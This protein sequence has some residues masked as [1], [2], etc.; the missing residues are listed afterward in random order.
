MVKQKS[1]ELLNVPVMKDRFT[2]ETYVTFDDLMMTEIKR[3]L[4]LLLKRLP[5]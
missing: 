5:T 1:D 2:E 4:H 3:K